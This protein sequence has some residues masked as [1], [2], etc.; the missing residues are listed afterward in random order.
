MACIYKL[1]NKITGKIYVGQTTDIKCRIRHY[2]SDYNNFHNLSEA[3]QKRSIDAVIHEY[4][5]E[6]FEFSIIEDNVPVDNLDARETFWINELHATDPE[7]GY[8]RDKV[9]HRDGNRKSR[10]YTWKHS[11]KDKLR[12]SQGI[13]LYDIENDEIAW[14]KSAKVFSDTLGYD[15]SIITRA[16]RRGSKVDGCYIFYQDDDKRYEAMLR[17]YNMKKDS[18]NQSRIKSFHEYMFSFNAIDELVMRM[19]K[20]GAIQYSE[21]DDDF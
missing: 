15:R 4:G 2:R 17:I 12:L 11:N 1:T 16:I 9:G 6:N 19:N 5:L 14:L 7:Y 13:I 18:K 10:N 3:R 20:H 8:N 21:D